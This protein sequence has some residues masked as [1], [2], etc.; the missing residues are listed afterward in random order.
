MLGQG[1]ALV[2]PT[3]GYYE[4]E[5]LGSE[6]LARFGVDVRRYDLRD[7]EGFRR[8]CDG[9][10]RS[11]S[12]RRPPTRRSPSPTSPRPRRPRTRAARCCAATTRSRTPLLQRPLDLGADLAWQSATKYLAGPLRSARRRRD[13]ARRR[14]ARA[15]RVRC[16]ARSAACWRPIPAWLLLRGLRTLH[17]RLAAPGARRRP[18]WRE[19]LAAHP[20]VSAV[21]Y[22][23]PA[24]P[25]RARRRRAPD[26]GRASAA[27]WP[28]S[29]RRRDAPGTRGAP[30]AGAQR[31]QPRRRRDADRA[32]RPASSRKAACRR[33][34]CASPSASSTSTTSG[35]TSSRRL[36]GVRPARRSD[37]QRELWI[38]LAPRGSLRT[39]ATRVLHAE[40][41]LAGRT[42][43]SPH[44]GRAAARRR[45][46]GRDRELAARGAQPRRG[47]AR[48][49]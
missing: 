38:P 2:I 46:L 49:A 31:D 35:P 15:P 23:G 32:A 11:R 14:A 42:D 19:R 17:V 6:V 45:A 27:C 30:A 37:A 43:A 29:C 24:R 36:A 9:R 48:P 22:P 8:A 34:C 3:S 20:A 25:P 7:P 41:D 5:L 47:G 16:G 28:S 10:R 1:K 18:S 39:D 44:G 33:A 40:R 4:V 13:D 21:H 26:A 12:S